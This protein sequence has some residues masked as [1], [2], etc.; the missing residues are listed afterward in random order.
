MWKSTP[1]PSVPSAPMDTRPSQVAR[2]ESCVREAEL[3]GLEIVPASLKAGLKEC[4]D[5]AVEDLKLEDP[6][7]APPVPSCDFPPRGHPVRSKSR[8]LLKIEMAPGY[9]TWEFPNRKPPTVTNAHSWSPSSKILDD[10]QN[11]KKWYT[12]NFAGAC[13]FCTLLQCE[14]HLA[15]CHWCSKSFCMIHWAPIDHQCTMSY[16]PIQLPVSA[17]NPNQIVEIDEPTQDIVDDSE[18]LDGIWR[19]YVFYVTFMFMLNIKNLGGTNGFRQDHFHSQC[20]TTFMRIWLLT[21]IEW[22]QISFLWRMKW[23]LHVHF[24]FRT[25]VFHTF[26]NLRESISMVIDF[27]CFPFAGMSTEQVRSTHTH[28]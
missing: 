26:V 2:I 12:N 25:V 11:C 16:A 8:A 21:W 17:P 10:N 27:Q 20:S 24:C 4:A 23:L 3:L 15:V 22:P 18:S 9:E 6:V 7:V 14:T 1:P 13:K 5:A 19:Y 28:S